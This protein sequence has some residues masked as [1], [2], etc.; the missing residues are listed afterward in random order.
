[1]SFLSHTPPA[2]TEHAPSAGPLGRRAGWVGHA[3]AIW[4][5]TYGVVALVWTI[6]G[7]GFPFGTNDRHGQVSL[8]RGLTPQV[9][10]PVFAAVLLAV[11]VAV[12]AMAGRWQG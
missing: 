7:T 11:A 9:G 1:M 12:L 3:A 6:T 2:A 8:L 10:A 5:A 4:A